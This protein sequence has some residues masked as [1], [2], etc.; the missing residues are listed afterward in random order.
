MGRHGRLGGFG[1][2]DLERTQ[3]HPVLGE[4]IIFATTHLR[5]DQSTAI[6]MA[7]VSQ[8][9]DGRAQPVR[10]GGGHDRPVEVTIAVEELT[11]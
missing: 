6:V 1:V 7:E 11:G 5:S 9:V 4:D 3:D 2:T 10:S 8:V